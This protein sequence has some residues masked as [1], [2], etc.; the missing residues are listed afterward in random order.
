MGS[1]SKVMSGQ[2]VLSEKVGERFAKV[3]M[4]A[5]FAHCQKFKKGRESAANYMPAILFTGRDGNFA[6]VCDTD[7][8]ILQ[9]MST[10][11]GVLV[12]IVSEEFCDVLWDLLLDYGKHVSEGLTPALLM[13]KPDGEFF[14]IEYDFDDDDDFVLL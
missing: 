3:I 9:T 4:Q 2:D 7:V 11:I 1:K 6:L 8:E 14:A 5:L 12:G 10:P 13:D